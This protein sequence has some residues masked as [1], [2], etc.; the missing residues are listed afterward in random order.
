MQTE[1]EDFYNAKCPQNT[2]PLLMNLQLTLIEN[3][4]ILEVA[5]HPHCFVE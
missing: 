4:P 2:S 3:Q 5:V 1:E